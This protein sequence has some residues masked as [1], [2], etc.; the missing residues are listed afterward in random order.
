M[1]NPWVSL[2]HDQLFPVNKAMNEKEQMEKAGWGGNKKF[3]NTHR[4]S[5]KYS[6]YLLP[7]R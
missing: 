6:R 5:F 7:C 2:I 4:P 1:P 3:I